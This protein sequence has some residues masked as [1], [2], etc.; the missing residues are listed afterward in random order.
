ML[1]ATDAAVSTLASFS[2]A[3]A[4]GAP[5]ARAAFGRDARAVA[6]VEA[7]CLA[8]ARYGDA[9]R[10]AWAD[11]V[12]LAVRLAKLDLLPPA[13][14]ALLQSEVWGGP[15]DGGGGGGDNAPEAA[16]AAN[17][18]AAGEQQQ[19]QQQQRKQGK[20]QA[21]HQQQQ[22]PQ[23]RRRPRLYGAGARAARQAAAAAGG[24]GGAGAGGGG[25]GGFLLSVSKLIALQEPEY[26]SKAAAALER[27][28][29]ALAAEVLT[30][31]C[32]LAEVFADSRFLRAE[33]LEA[34]VAALVAAPGPLSPPP[35]P[36]HHGDA[37]Q[38]QHHQQQQRHHH[39]HQQQDGAAGAGAVDWAAQEL[40]VDLL[41]AVLLRNRDRLP[42]LW[43]PVYERFAA[44]IGG[45][46]EAAR[47]FDLI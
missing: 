29:E 31:R 1:C 16:A 45:R 28:A 38:Q 34:L 39:H 41:T 20:E 12:D 37:Q 4:P 22:K 7:M 10:T 15:G 11:V 35:A 14:E 40:C 27:E 25:G 33:A 17:G 46:G 2:A 36:H 5:K 44:V 30:K 43:P 32:P 19:Q 23:T 24:G 21:D 8:A 3:L 26:A 18:S 47:C 6:A 9:L 13:L 42:A